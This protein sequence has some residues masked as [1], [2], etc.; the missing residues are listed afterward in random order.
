MDVNASNNIDLADVTHP[1]TKSEALTV[2][3]RRA[4]GSVDPS[5]RRQV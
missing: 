4:A 1:E 5:A 3:E 2:I